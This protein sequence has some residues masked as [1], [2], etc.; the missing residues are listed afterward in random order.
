M[1]AQ[2]AEGDEK[3]GNIEKYGLGGVTVYY[4]KTYYATLVVVEVDARLR[5]TAARISYL[6]LDRR[7]PPR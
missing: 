2:C 7:D 3:H 1:R 6:E 5:P 4:T